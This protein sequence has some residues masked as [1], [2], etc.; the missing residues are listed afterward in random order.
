[1]LL[2]KNNVSVALLGDKIN[3]QPVPSLCKSCLFSVLVFQI[4]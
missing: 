4:K 2:A 3:L 1:M